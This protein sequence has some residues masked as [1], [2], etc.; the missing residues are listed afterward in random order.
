MVGN[1]IDQRLFDII[2]LG[3]NVANRA[4]R[5]PQREENLIIYI[6]I[7]NRY[8]INGFMKA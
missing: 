5:G 6:N 3:R 1:G 7:N 4:R 2:A 8:L